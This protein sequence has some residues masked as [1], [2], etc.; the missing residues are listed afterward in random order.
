MDGNVE[1]K[2]CTS[3][4]T[5]DA[6]L[7]LFFSVVGN[8]SPSASSTAWQFLFE[9]FLLHSTHTNL[10]AFPRDAFLAQVQELEFYLRKITAGQD[11]MW[12]KEKTTTTIVI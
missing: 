4:I 12:G 10:F 7:P 5:N 9:F 2:G 8:L 6:G 3:G 1:V 11:G